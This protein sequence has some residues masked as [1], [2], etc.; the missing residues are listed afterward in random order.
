MFKNVFKTKKASKVE[1]SKIVNTKTVD[2]SKKV[3]VF[4]VIK[5]PLVT[6]KAAILSKDNIYIFKV[7]ND[8]TKKEVGEA[9][10]A[11]Y[12]VKPKDVRFTKAVI[13]S[14]RVRSIKNQA[15]YSRMKKIKKAYVQLKDTDKI[16]LA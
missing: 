16:Q 9:I 8:A 2:I 4:D 1:K 7:R 10:F 11:I 12:N 3:G 14:K 6:E 13:N 5:K 15:R